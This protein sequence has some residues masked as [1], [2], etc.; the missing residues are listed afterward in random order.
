M[1]T[2]LASDLIVPEVWGDAVMETV[3]GKAVLVPMADADD[4]LVGAPGDTV[5]FPKFDYIGDAVDLTEGVAMTTTKLTMSD[6]TATI[7]EAGKA[8]E[9]SDTAVLTAIGRPNDQARTCLL[10]TSD[11]ADEEL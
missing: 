9:L 7:K 4:Q 1:A 5:H 2:T 3:L 6:A 11:A 8:I 10:Y